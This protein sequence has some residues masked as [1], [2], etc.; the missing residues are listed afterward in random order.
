MAG[1]R[2][3]H[4][5]KVY[6]NGTKA[7]SDFTMDI[8]DQEFIV[9]VGPS[10][11]GKSTT[12]RMIAGLEDIS[13]G[14]LYIGDRIVND[15]E[16]KDRDIAMVFQNYALYPHM[17]VYE[18]MAFGLKLR[19]VPNAEIHEKV[20]WAAQVLDLTEYLDRKPKAMSGG[21]RQRVALGRAILR[22]PKVML[23]DEP[24]SNLDAKLRAQMRSEIAK[25]HDQLKTTFIYVTHDQVEAM[26][27]GTRVVV[28]RLGR[29]MQI[30][31]PKNLYDYPNNLFVAGFIGTPQMNFFNATLTKNGSKIHIDFKWS[32]ESLDVPQA[33]LAKVKPQYFDGTSEVV[34]GIRCE[35]ISL[36][37][38]VV[39]KSD[40]LIN[41]RISHFE[42]L[43]NE[44]LI[45]ADIN[46]NGDGFS[47]SSTRV[48][49]KGTSTYGLVKG[50]MAKAAVNGSKIHMF[51]KNTENTINPRV[52]SDNLITGKIQKNVLKLGQLSYELPQ[53]IALADG[54]YDIM[55]PTSA[56]ALGND[57]TNTA[58]LSSLENV[59]GLNI[60]GLL[61]ADQLL[62]TNTKEELSL[63]KKYSVELDFTQLEFIQE[64]SVVHHAISEYDKL[65]AIFLNHATA[66]TFVGDT[67][68]S[69]VQ[70][71]LQ[72]VDDTYLPKIQALTEEYQTAANE[73]KKVDSNS[74]AAK[75]KPIIDEKKQNLA[76]EVARLTAEFNEASKQLKEEHHAK[77]NE[78]TERVESTYAKIK[79]D[80]LA[81]FES[82]KAMNKDKDAY[83]KRAT[84]IRT[85]KANFNLEKKNELDKQINLEAVRYESDLN[86]LKGNYKRNVD[87]LKK[88][89]KDFVN[90][91]NN[92]A[93]PLKKLDKE[94]R[95]N[96][97]E[98]TSKYQNEK[99]L[100][101]II[102]FLKI[103]DLL[104]LCTD[105]IS[106]K[107]IQSLGV[108]V[109][110]KQYL[111]EIPHN[112]YKETQEEGLEIQVLELKDYGKRKYLHCQMDDGAGVKELY[113]ETERESVDTKTI[114]VV[115]DVTKIHIT[116][117][118]MEIKIY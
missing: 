24:L 17:T 111:V 46:E 87:S 16:P 3:E 73:A 109:F 88:D 53:A 5:Y 4:I 41:V 36:D 33:V 117:K 27:L 13:A 107:M 98:L 65:N 102:F 69:V 10:G 81:A 31:T 59:D 89:F 74:I 18:N 96:L 50:A 11:C 75:N 76:K 43:G 44:T 61:I 115:F 54:N 63:N 86:A 15:V 112:A 35:H 100:A 93:Y 49:I 14:E 70:D 72:N 103:N 56:I 64:G 25:L 58:E 83:R 38:E 94:Y 57:A 84:E 95:K 6:P 52:P 7:V 2:L 71:R 42:E 97:K 8:Q 114:K 23:L 82:F 40:S 67:Y 32:K 77:N 39:A 19:H 60:A 51:D 62:F 68:D 1:L 110:T 34:V 9:F 104:T 116:E 66:K 99:N 20:L 106:N 21:Q 29:I 80:E 30:D 85:F 118:S 108:K 37:P 22:N 105:A 79:E 92:E 26:T 28:M 12:L 113:I 55:I 90:Q 78:I 45:Y 91:C 47:E 48:I 101:N